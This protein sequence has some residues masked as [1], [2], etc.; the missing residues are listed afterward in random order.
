MADMTDMTD[1]EQAKEA[2]K[3]SG[4]RK[5]A[6]IAARLRGEPKRAISEETA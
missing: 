2:R 3:Q 1:A 6:A 5:A 4:R